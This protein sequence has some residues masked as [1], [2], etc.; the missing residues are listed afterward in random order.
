MCSNIASSKIK[1]ELSSA[2]KYFWWP[3]K[4]EMTDWVFNCSTL[5]WH[6]NGLNHYIFSITFSLA[7][8]Q[9]TLFS[10]LRAR[11]W[12]ISSHNLLRRSKLHYKQ[13]QSAF[14]NNK[15]PII[16]FNPPR[17]Y[18]T[19]QIALFIYF[20][21]VLLQINSFGFLSPYGELALHPIHLHAP[22]RPCCWVDLPACEIVRQRRHSHPYPTM[23]QGQV[24]LGVTTG[25]V[26][27]GAI[28]S[29]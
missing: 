2:S 14:W 23:H 26:P 22:H 19:R 10:H 27:P 11:M 6:W 3:I 5:S 20:P 16:T 18:T 9:T 28:S 21:S 8:L 13:G 4:F 29:H 15:I 1:N 25:L 7:P 24:H 17:C 12:L